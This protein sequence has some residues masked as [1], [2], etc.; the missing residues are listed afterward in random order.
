MSLLAADDRAYLSA[1]HPVRYALGP[2]EAPLI[3]LNAADA[4]GCMWASDV[5]EGWDAPEVTTPIDRRSAGHGGYVGE[6]TYEARVLTFEGTV[7]APTAAALGDAYRRLLRALLGSLSGFVRYT[8][9]DE[10]PAPMGLWVRPTGKPRW[11][12]PDDRVADFA[13]VLVAEDPIKTGPAATYGPV[14]LAGT[15]TEGG[16]IAP[17]T[18]PLT[19]TG[20]VNSA[21]YVTVPNAG[22]EDAHAIYTITGPVPQPIVQVTT[23]EFAHLRLDLGAL[24]TAVIDTADGTVTVNGVN[25]YDA[26]GPGSVF[27]LIPPG[28]AEVRFRSFT[29]GADPA[30]ALAVTTAPAWR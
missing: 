16:L 17:F 12:V 8:H 28:G 21:V 14:R 9:L 30:A 15:A 2:P 23:G 1:V 24:D 4:Y 20:S 22:D 13:F 26:W 10:A 25:R 19:F 29:G 7:A 27:P 18:M 5:P 3:V 6:S 11:Q